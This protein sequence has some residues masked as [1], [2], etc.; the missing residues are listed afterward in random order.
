M[1]VSAADTI[2]VLSVQSLSVDSSPTL[3][4]FVQLLVKEKTVRRRQ[5]P[6]NLLSGAGQHGQ[7]WLVTS[8]AFLQ[9]LTQVY[10]DKHL[11][12]PICSIPHRPPS[13][14]NLAIELLSARFFT[15]AS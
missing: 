6:N 1:N 5:L 3:A 9:F 7:D 2:P 10:K 13:N 12:I 8:K 15:T 14:Y 11:S 4:Q